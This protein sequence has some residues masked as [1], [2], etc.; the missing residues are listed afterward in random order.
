[1]AVEWTQGVMDV[2][3]DWDTV[4]LLTGGVVLCWLTAIITAA[5]LFGHGSRDE[6]PVRATPMNSA[7]RGHKARTSRD[8]GQQE[9]T[10]NG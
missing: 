1:M 3:G 10:G 7:G 2:S 8:D 9:G 6:R 4:V 5:V